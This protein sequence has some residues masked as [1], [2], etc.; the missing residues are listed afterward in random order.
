MGNLKQAAQVP[1][2]SKKSLKKL[3]SITIADAVALGGTEAV[4]AIGGP[5]LSVQVGRTDFLPGQTYNPNVPLDLLEG[6]RNG[7]EVSD[8]FKRSGLT[9]REMTALLGALLIMQKI[10]QKVIKLLSVNVE[11]LDV[12]LNI[13]VLPKMILPQLQLLNLMM[14]MMNLVYLTIN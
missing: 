13:N 10:G 8:A 1:V 11:K 7:R 14:M 9:E 6:K 4:E 3:T 12:C 2:D 5:G